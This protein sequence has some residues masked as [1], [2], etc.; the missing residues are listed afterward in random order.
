[1]HL[2]LSVERASLEDEKV[3]LRALGFVTVDPE[4]LHRRPPSAGLDLTETDDAGGEH[5]KAALAAVSGNELPDHRGRII[6]KGYTHDEQV[7]GTENTATHIRP[8]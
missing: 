3:I 4:P 1:M 8:N 2:L 5:Q 7:T 6:H